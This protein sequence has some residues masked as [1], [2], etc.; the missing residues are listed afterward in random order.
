MTALCFTYHQ[1]GSEVRQSKWKA[2]Q[3]SCRYLDWITLESKGSKN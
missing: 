2:Y 3:A 1:A